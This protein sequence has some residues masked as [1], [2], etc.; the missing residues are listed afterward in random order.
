MAPGQRARGDPMA[1]S[2]RPWIV[3]PHGPIEELDENLWT[4]ESKV[5]GVPIRRRMA[6]IKRSDGTLAFFHAVP[7][8]EAALARVTAWGKPAILVLGHDQ[9][10]IDATPFAGKLG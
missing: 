2:A 10:G 9:H 7:L 6:I 3:T 4:V 5:P 1:K 8:D